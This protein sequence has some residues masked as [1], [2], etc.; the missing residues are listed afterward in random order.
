MKVSV[1]F[2]KKE[3]YTSGAASVQLQLT[4]CVL[5]ADKFE[6]KGNSVVE[7]LARNKAEK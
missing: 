6:R 1:F 5:Y 4:L 2:N 7:W 3:C